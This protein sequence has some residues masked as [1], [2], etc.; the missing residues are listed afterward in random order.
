MELAKVFTEGVY[1]DE[2]IDCIES[3]VHRDLSKF[4]SARYS[5]T[6]ALLSILMFP[7]KETL[8]Y[9][10]LVPDKADPA[11]AYQRLLRKQRQGI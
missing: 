4:E 9:C 1:T 2:N 5:E 10:G 6:C 3:L 7:L 8:I 11:R